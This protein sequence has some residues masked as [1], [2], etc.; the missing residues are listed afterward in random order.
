MKRRTIGIAMGAALAIGVAVVS[1]ARA[2][3]VPT[4]C[5]SSADAQCTVNS[6]PC[7][8]P[9][10]QNVELT[11]SPSAGGV[12]MQVVTAE[13]PTGFTGACLVPFLTYAPQLPTVCYSPG[14]N[15][16]YG[17]GS[18]QVTAPTAVVARSYG[19]TAMGYDSFQ[20]LTTCYPHDSDGTCP[21][22]AFAVSRSCCELGTNM[23]SA[24]GK[25]ATG[26]ANFSTF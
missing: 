3:S 6:G 23:V 24:D 4:Y 13:P 21:T 5:C 9:T 1:G 19:S 18:T 16:Q 2:Q 7:A 17:V 25:Y 26:I 20:A 22:A 10:G 15:I 8:S 14:G 11:F 12:S